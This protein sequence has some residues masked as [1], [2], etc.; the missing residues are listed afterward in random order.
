MP[1]L[2][3][4]EENEERVKKIVRA[5]HKLAK[6]LL[7]RTPSSPCSAKSPLLRLLDGERYGTTTDSMTGVRRWK[8]R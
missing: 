7:Q 4:R 6:Q 3:K 2:T 5:T 8:E 1:T